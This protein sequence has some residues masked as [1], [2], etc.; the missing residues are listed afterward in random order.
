MRRICIGACLPQLPLRILH[1]SCAQIGEGHYGSTADGDDVIL[2]EWIVRARS[3]IPARVTQYSEIQFHTGFIRIICRKLEMICHF[4]QIIL[5]AQMLITTE[6]AIC[7]Q[8][9]FELTDGDYSQ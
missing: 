4:G 5:A 7:G 3:P 6:S 1:F 8:V 9:P 2:R